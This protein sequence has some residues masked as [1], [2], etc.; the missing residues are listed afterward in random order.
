MQ[1]R[2]Y[3][4]A[5]LNS[6]RFRSINKLMN[7]ITNTSDNIYENLCDADIRLSVHY[8][9]KLMGIC[10]IAKNNITKYTQHDI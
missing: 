9:D 10:E 7:E 5:E 2:S 8:L 4:N 6:S 1:S 3:K